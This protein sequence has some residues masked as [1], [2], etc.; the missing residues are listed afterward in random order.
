MGR[1]LFVYGSQTGI[2][3]S[4]AQGFHEQAQ[5]QGIDATLKCMNEVKQVRRV[6]LVLCVTCTLFPNSE[7]RSCLLSLPPL[8]VCLSVG[9]QRAVQ[10]IVTGCKAQTRA[11]VVVG[12]AHL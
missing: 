6:R 5:K 2:T 10:P 9:V 12:L 11:L 4:I 1:V 8:P 3:E 7:C